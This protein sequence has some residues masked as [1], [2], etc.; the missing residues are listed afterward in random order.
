M[1]TYAIYFLVIDKFDSCDLLI[2]SITSPR[3]LGYC[4]FLCGDSVVVDS[5]FTAG[6]ES[7]FELF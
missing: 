7:G 5:L 1:A 6:F 3:G 2:L 4:P